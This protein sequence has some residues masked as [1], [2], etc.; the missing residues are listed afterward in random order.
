MKKSFKIVL[1]L[2]LGTLPFICGG[3]FLFEFPCEFDNPLDPK[4][5][6]KGPWSSYRKMPGVFTRTGTEFRIHLPWT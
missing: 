5:N 6:R 1:I 4:L 3:C 2:L